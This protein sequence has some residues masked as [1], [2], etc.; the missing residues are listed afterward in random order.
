MKSKSWYCCVGH[1]SF[2]VAVVRVAKQGQYV[3]NCE[4][5][6]ISVNQSEVSIVCDIQSK[7]SIVCIIQSEMSIIF[8]NQS[9]MSIVCINQSEMSIVCINQSEV[10]ISL[11]QPIRDEYLPVKKI[12]ASLVAHNNTSIYNKAKLRNLLK[13]IKIWCG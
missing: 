11:Y 3:A 2:V 9:E 1:E 6:S 5:E 10:S 7:M 12:A 4:E 8:I 13:S